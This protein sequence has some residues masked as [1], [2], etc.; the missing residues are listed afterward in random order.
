M[1]TVVLSLSQCGRNLS[2]ITALIRERLHR[3][4]EE[5]EDAGG[6]TVA[7][8]TAL[9]R[10]R[11]CKAGDKPKLSSLWCSALVKIVRAGLESK[12]KDAPKDT[13]PPALAAASQLPEP[14]PHLARLIAKNMRLPRGLSI[15]MEPKRR[16][17][18]K[19]AGIYYDGMGPL[20]R[21]LGNYRDHGAKII[22]E[23]SHHELGEEQDKYVLTLHSNIKELC[24]RWEKYRVKNGIT[25]K[26]LKEELPRKKQLIIDANPDFADNFLALINEPDAGETAN[27]E[28]RENGDFYF[29][30]TH[31]EAGFL[32]F[33]YDTKSTNAK[34]TAA[35][36]RSA[37]EANIGE[38]RL[39][40][41]SSSPFLPL[42]LLPQPQQLHASSMIAYCA[43]GS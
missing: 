34:K 13:P 37:A 27:I 35:A 2:S 29:V 5:D 11:A 26:E 7:G 38:Y 19:G 6:L 12:Q 23:M 15:R 8:A 32:M 21:R 17:G 28:V 4:L 43:S 24:D 30:G 18:T 42:P 14:E 10:F 33:K 31:Y 16:G 9:K 41:C 3:M 22:S 36:K 1:T 25:K 39:T 20:E 40:S